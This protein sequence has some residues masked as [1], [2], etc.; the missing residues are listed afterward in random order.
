MQHIEIFV[1][2]ILLYD[3]LYSAIHPM[4]C[5]QS[6]VMWYNLKQDMPY[7]ILSEKSSIIMSALNIFALHL[8]NNERKNCFHG[9]DYQCNIILQ[10]A[11]LPASIYSVAMV[12]SSTNKDKTCRHLYVMACQKWVR[13]EFLVGILLTVTTRLEQD[14][15]L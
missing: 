9:D 2:S 11:L 6:D 14:Q 4:K 1:Y 13:Q 10:P 7:E 8:Y 3:G 12:T 5:L 15:A